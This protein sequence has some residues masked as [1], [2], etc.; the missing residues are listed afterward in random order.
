MKALTIKQPWAELILQKRKTIELR[1]WNTKFRG[2]FLIHTSKNSDKKAMKKFG[3]QDLPCGFV[4]GQA[5]LMEVKKY[6][7]KKEFQKDENKHLVEGDF[8]KHG[9]IIKNIKRIKPFS[10]KGRLNF[11]ELK[12]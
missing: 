9:F 10:I 8:S 5:K 3:F 2:D 11:W 6:K 4:I 1:N 7:N 12:K